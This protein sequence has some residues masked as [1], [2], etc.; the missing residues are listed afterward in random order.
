[1][2]E[3][4]GGNFGN[5]FLTAGV[6]KALSFANSVQAGAE[7][8]E[9]IGKSMAQAAVGGTLSKVTGGKFANGAITAAIQYVVNHASSVIGK[10]K[11][12]E[13]KAALTVSAKAVSRLLGLKGDAL[14]MSVDS[15]GNF[16]FSGSAK[17]KGLKLDISS[18]GNVKV[19]AG[20]LLGTSFS[21]N[22]SELGTTLLNLGVLQV[23]ITAHDNM[24]IN[25]EIA[26]GSFV[27][28]K[29]YSGFDL[30]SWAPIQMVSE[31]I[32]QQNDIVCYPSVRKYMSSCN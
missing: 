13:T 32:Q 25:Y 11:P 9:I 2:A 12:Q 21:I 27:G 29:L 31:H 6:M 7:M 26:V 10:P 24:I 8:G 1:M 18:S 22:D 23:S 30:G 14:G 28:V 3:L 4:Q 17:L 15:N 20:D 5:G 16:S 19:T